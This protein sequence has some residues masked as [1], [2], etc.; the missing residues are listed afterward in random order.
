MALK[1]FALRLTHKDE[2]E[3]LYAVHDIMDAN[4]KEMIPVLIEQL[5]KEESQAVRDAI[6]S[7][8]KHMEMS[9]TPYYE[10]LFGLFFSPD[11]FLRN[12]AVSIFGS[13][14]EDAVAFL[15]SKLDH[16]DRE[17]RKLILDS[18]VDIGTPEAI[19]AIRAA[20]Y[21]PAKNVQITAVEYLGRLGDREA[22]EDMIE[23]FR[24]DEEP[25]LRSSIIN[26]LTEIGDSSVIKEL[27]IILA[28]DGKVSDINTVLLPDVMRMV[29]RLGNINEIRE[30]LN[31]FPY[32][33][34]YA[35][36]VANFI[37]EAVR[38]F[39]LL[40]DSE[41]VMG[42]MTAIINDPEVD[43]DIKNFCEELQNE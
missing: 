12:A 33:K 22:L 26:A 6:V 23:L 42:L 11:A 43:E 3:R 14:K 39:P 30:L 5:E 29:A 19:M 2:G 16:T 9:I 37:L 7:A 32:Q 36:D 38:R 25:M 40:K 4:I 18:L 15:T 27:L 35:R 21:D 10:R 20:I 28:P 24:K 41:E 17:V 34:I 8:L 1:D 31:S 13:G